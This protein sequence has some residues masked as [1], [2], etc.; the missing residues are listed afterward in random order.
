MDQKN[1][2]LDHPNLSH[3]STERLSRKPLRRSTLYLVTMFLGG[4]FYYSFDD[5]GQTLPRVERATYIL[6]H[7][8][9]T[10]ALSIA[11]S[12]VLELFRLILRKWKEKKTGEKERRDPIWFE[13][14]EG[15]MGIWI[16]FMIAFAILWFLK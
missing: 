14:L 16:L 7:A 2:N 11:L 3:T 6:I 5:Y 1:E 12:L 10:M 9:K 8:L 15:G 13:V 4:M